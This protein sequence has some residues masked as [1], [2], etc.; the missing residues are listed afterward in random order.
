M[1]AL[2]L[3]VAILLLST[4]LRRQKETQGKSDS[5]DVEQQKTKDRI[6]LLIPHLSIITLKCKE[7]DSPIKIHSIHGWVKNQNLITCYIQEI[8]LNFKEQ[9]RLKLKR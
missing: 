8:H 7:I 3:Q 6:A 2:Y 1:S 4:K 9:H 5:G